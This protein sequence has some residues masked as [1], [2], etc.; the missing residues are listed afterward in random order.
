MTKTLPPPTINANVSDGDVGYSLLV[1]VAGGVRSVPLPPGR[2]FTIGRDPGNDIVIRDASVSREHAIIHPDRPPSIEDGGSRN[3]TRVGGR[4]V[5]Q[6]QRVPLHHGASIEVGSVPMFVQSALQ[7]KVPMVPAGPSSTGPRFLLGE[8]AMVEVVRLAEL[9]A[10]SDLRVLILGETGVGKELLAEAVHNFS[11]RRDKPLVRFNCSAFPETLVESE[12][13]GHERGAFTGAVSSKMGLFQSAAGGTLFLDEVGELT[14][15]TQ[16]KLLRILETR[17]VT[18]LGAVKPTKVD[19]RFISATN[20]DLRQMIGA[21]LFRSDLYFR[22]NGMS[23]MIPPLRKRPREVVMLASQFAQ[24]F[25]TGLGRPSP[26]F[27]NEAIALLE[28]YRWPG[29]VRELKNVVERAV[30]LSPA[31]LVEASVLGM[32]VECAP[33]SDSPGIPKIGSDFPAA[34]VTMTGVRA[35][36]TTGTPNTVDLRDELARRER[37]KI[38]EA[39]ERAGTQ[40]EAAKLLGMSRRTLINRLEEF[41]IARPRKRR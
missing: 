6:G 39:I 15:S 26:E 10:Q 21:Q 30:L 40:A 17:E 34:E 11:P 35:I 8:S 19:V 9:V 16:A 22:L 14:L 12:L 18:P 38:V 37:T 3:G 13:F 27:T 29:N 2:R 24:D 31:S 4:T 41:E 23:L 20:R 28:S 7:A 25:A 33:V 1:C 36:D 5:G 32:D